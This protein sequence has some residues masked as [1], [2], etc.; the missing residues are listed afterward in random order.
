MV[1]DKRHI[2]I[3]VALITLLLLI[4]FGCITLEKRNQIKVKS[5]SIIA[6]NFSELVELGVPLY[7]KVNT[8]DGVIDV[9]L[10]DGIAKHQNGDTYMLKNDSIVFFHVPNCKKDK[11]DCDWILVNESQRVYSWF[12][13]LLPMKGDINDIPGENFDCDVI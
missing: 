3:A 13:E 2:G 11:Y 10:N 5:L 9:L 8:S 4:L 7:C 6:N 1:L 12:V